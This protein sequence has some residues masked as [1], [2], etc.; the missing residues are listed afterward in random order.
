[1]G[2]LKPIVCWD[3]DETL[4]YFRPLEFQYLGQKPPAGMPPVRLKEGIR[5]V[6]L[7]LAE[8]THVVTSAAIGDYARGVL[9]QHGLD[10]LFADVVGREDGIFSGEGK[11]YKVVGDR[12]GLEEAELSRS[13]VIVGNDSKR[14]PDLRFRQIVMIFDD[15]MPDLP[16]EPLAVVLRRLLS[17]GDGQLK[18]G[19]DRLHARASA[20]NPSKP[21]LALDEGVAFDIDYWGSYAEDKLH[22]MIIRPRFLANQAN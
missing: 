11:D 8:F 6:I 10:G 2:S 1:M 5:E 13:L 7:S 19:F 21:A 4:G 15:Q 3:F 12:F 16:S 20:A 9:K 17:E 22:P 18:R 14:D